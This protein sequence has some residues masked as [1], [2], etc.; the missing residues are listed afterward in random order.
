MRFTLLIALGCVLRLS[1]LPAPAQS[2][3]PPPGTYQQSCADIILEGSALHARCQ[4][5]AGNWRT[6]TLSEVQ[7]CTEEI[8]N[9]NG[10]LRCGNRAA[11]YRG[12][13]DGYQGGYLGAYQNDYHAVMPEGDYLLSCR[14]ISMN[15]DQLRAECQANDG[16][17]RRTALD[18]TSMCLGPV[19]TSNGLL[20]CR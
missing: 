12:F 8:V 10:R 5:A 2:V 16:R 13:Q 14:N 1:A 19:T 18:N 4:D 7:S 17:W 20:T 9:D 15:G 6:S 11:L 3:A